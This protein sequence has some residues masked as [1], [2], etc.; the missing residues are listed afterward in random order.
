MVAAA[1]RPVLVET[2]LLLKTLKR[3]PPVRWGR[4]A[5]AL[6]GGEYLTLRRAGDGVEAEVRLPFPAARERG[7][8][9]PSA[10][11]VDS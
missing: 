5:V 6:A 9:S 11:V 3:L 4:D 10:L 1:T 2:G 8:A 7:Y